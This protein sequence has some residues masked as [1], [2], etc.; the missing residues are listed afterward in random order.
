M[1]RQYLIF[2]SLFFSCQK[3]RPEYLYL[4]SQP[5]MAREPH[6]ISTAHLSKE[7]KVLVVWDNSGSMDIEEEYV[8]VF[9]T[10]LFTSLFEDDQ[11][12]VTLGITTTDKQ[13]PFH[14][15][16]EKK[17]WPHLTPEELAEKFDEAIQFRINNPSSRADFE[18]VFLLLLEFPRTKP[19]LCHRR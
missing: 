13:T 2:L 10:A 19:L 4:L 16:L 5:K 15:I 8:K 1:K 17:N 7:I 9:F 3:D 12:N 14:F 11:I 6:V 18:Y